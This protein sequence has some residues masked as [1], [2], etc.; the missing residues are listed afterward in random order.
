MYCPT[1][2]EL[3]YIPPFCEYLALYTLEIDLQVARI[4]HVRFIRT[5]R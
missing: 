4:G 2:F 3:Y 5:S 1:H